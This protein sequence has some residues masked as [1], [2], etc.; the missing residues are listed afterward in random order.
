MI[1]TVLMCYLKCYF[2][3]KRALML[4]CILVSIFGCSKH[5][6]E[7]LTENNFNL[8]N[9]SHQIQVKVKQEGWGI[10]A[11]I[12]DGNVTYVHEVIPEKINDT[13]IVD[14]TYEHQ[15][16]SW[17]YRN[18]ELNG[19]TGL[20]FD[21]RINDGK[22]IDVNIGKNDTGRDRELKIA[23][24]WRVLPDYIVVHQAR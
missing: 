21:I 12:V 2:G 14:G 16:F 10:S 24:T 3:K 8:S 4:M 6:T 13:V 9:S 1:N 20:W 18:N 11:I 5:Q 19:I 17:T 22:A 7:F 15:G 23:V